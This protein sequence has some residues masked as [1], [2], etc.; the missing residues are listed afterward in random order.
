MMNVNVAEMAG[1][2][3]EEPV[4][5]AGRGKTLTEVMKPIS[6]GRGKQHSCLHTVL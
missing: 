6:L 3:N 4:A 1:V 2:K 5:V